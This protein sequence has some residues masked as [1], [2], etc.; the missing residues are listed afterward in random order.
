MIIFM[1]SNRPKINKKFEGECFGFDKRINIISRPFRHILIGI[2]VYTGYLF[3]NFGYLFVNF[4]SVLNRQLII[5]RWK[6]QKNVQLMKLIHRN[7][8]SSCCANLFVFSLGGRAMNDYYFCRCRVLSIYDINDWLHMGIT[9]NG[10]A[11]YH[12]RAK[13]LSLCAAQNLASNVIYRSFQLNFGIVRPNSFGKK[14][15]LL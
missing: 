5:F 11:A 15:R 1:T 3:V 8:S 7:Y 13:L 14:W 2:D 4:G 12:P 6:P 9:W 10:F